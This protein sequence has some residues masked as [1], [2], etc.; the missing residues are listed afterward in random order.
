[1]VPAAELLTEALALAERIAA[2]SSLT[3]K[4]LKRSLLHGADMPLPAALAHEQ[5]M[6]SLVLDSHDAHEGCRAF[7]QKRPAQFRGE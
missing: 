6:I 5:A 7:L 4:F 3:L 2:K 1:M